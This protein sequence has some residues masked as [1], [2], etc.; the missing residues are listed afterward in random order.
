MPRPA[1]S[2]SALEVF[3]LFCT[4]IGLG[5]VYSIMS[6]TGVGAGATSRQLKDMKRRGLLVSSPGSRRQVFFSLTTKGESLL[7]EALEQDPI[8]WGTVAQSSYD[9]LP[10]IIFFC[11]L[12]G[13]PD[14]AYAVLDHTES[15]LTRKVQDA[16][17]EFKR[18]LEI[19]TQRRKVVTARKEYASPEYL[20]A[21]YRMVAA[22]VSSTDA[23][24]KLEGLD[25]LRQTISELPPSPTTFL[26]DRAGHTKRGSDV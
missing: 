23:K 16:T 4:K 20:A 5:T 19:L 14:E 13:R 12:R 22:S 6:Q 10:R 1:P 17:R 7:H 15:T 25:E 26:N 8:H 18:S 3:L 11:W 9:S 24:R 2:L 21:G